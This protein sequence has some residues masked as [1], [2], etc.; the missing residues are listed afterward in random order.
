MAAPQAPGPQE[1][2]PMPSMMPMFIVLIMIFGLYMLD[3]E[4]H[5]IGGLLNYVFGIFD[6]GGQYPVATLMLVGAIMVTLSTIL[7]ALTTDMIKQTKNQQIMNAFN[8]ELRQA[9]LDNNL[10]KVKKLTEMQPTMMAKNMESSQQ[11]MKMM[12]YTM[13]VI[14]PI[15]LW[16]RYFVDITVQAAGTVIIHVPWAEVSLLS[17]VWFF[18]AW[19]LIYTLI[20]IPLGQVINRLIRSYK[21]KK[22]L[23]ELE[24]TEEVEVA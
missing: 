11:M 15:F 18:P 3:G 20:S 1:M 12:P 7:R 2:P 10:Y 24:A 14:I 23:S 16:I 9:R 13:I 22:R 17:N 8:Q 6:F 5:L 19:I 21:F 4:N